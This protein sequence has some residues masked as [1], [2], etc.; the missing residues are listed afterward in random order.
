VDYVPC[1]ERTFPFRLAPSFERRYG[2]YLRWL[3]HLLERLGPTC[4]RAL[5]QEA[6][7]NYDDALLMEILS[8]GWTP[9]AGEEA[10]DREAIT[11]NLVAEWFPRPIETVS[12]DEAQR[13]VEETPP[14]LQ[15]GQHFPSLDVQRESTAYEALHLVLDGEALL[16]ESL[17]DRHGKE[18]QLIAYDVIR[19]GRIAAAKGETGTVEEF[20]AYQLAAPTEPNVF[21]SGLE[22]EVI[23][24]SDREYVTHIKECEWARYFR[25]HHPRVGYLVACSTDEVGIRAFNER[26]RMQR[27]STLMEGGEVCDFRIYAVQGGAEE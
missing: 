10:T 14:L 12:P 11:A 3:A 9:V 16:A 6:F 8:S 7:A 24:A 25:D 1:R 26:L 15:I 18:G 5:W 20:M 22:S 19:D 4:T 21:T 2:T 27:T 17:I 13:L 23:R